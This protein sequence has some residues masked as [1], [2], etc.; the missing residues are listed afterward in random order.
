[1]KRTPIEVWIK[2][3]GYGAQVKLAKRCGTHKQAITRLLTTNRST[4]VVVEDGDRLWIER[5]TAPR[6]KII[7]PE[8]SKRKTTRKT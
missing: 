5:T 6:V 7:G 3:T 4:S 1:M 2:Q 8:F